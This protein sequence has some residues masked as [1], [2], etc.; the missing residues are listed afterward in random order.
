MNKKAVVSEALLPKFHL[1][2]LLLG[3]TLRSLSFEAGFRPLVATHLRTIH[4]KARID[5][6]VFSRRNVVC[7]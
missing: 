5:A 3:F 1:Q 2:L 6:L 7:N 4:L